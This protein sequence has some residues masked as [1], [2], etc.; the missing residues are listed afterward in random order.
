MRSAILFGKINS[1]ILRARLPGQPF[2]GQSICLDGG[3]W[4]PVKI[5][6]HGQ[7]RAE[8][9][10]FF[11]KAKILYFELYPIRAMLHIYFLKSEE[12]PCPCGPPSSTFLTLAYHKA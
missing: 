8:L 7:Q 11:K 5:Q 10:H 1:H 3:K 2:G 9:S 6:R 12:S 4:N